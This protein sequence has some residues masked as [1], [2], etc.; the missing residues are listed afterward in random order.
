MSNTLYAYLN[1]NFKKHP[2]PLQ[3]ATSAVY[4]TVIVQVQRLI[5]YIL[6]LWAMCAW[7]IS[8]LFFFWCFQCFFIALSLSHSLY[9]THNRVSL[10]VFF[11]Y[12]ITM[13]NARLCKF[14]WISIE[15]KF[16]ASQFNYSP[17]FSPNAAYK[18]IHEIKKCNSMWWKPFDNNSN[19]RI[20]TIDYTIFVCSVRFFYLVQLALSSL[21]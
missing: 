7:R 11:F 8:L 15:Y 9:V 1:N 19:S 13:N 2:N 16:N 17:I 3:V 21:L 5:V 4:V 18:N 14:T 20:I 12:Q 6:V 10:L